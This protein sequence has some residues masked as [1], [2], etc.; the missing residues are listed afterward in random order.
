MDARRLSWYIIFT[1]N[2]TLA[3]YCFYY[4]YGY[5]PAA[6]VNPVSSIELKVFENHFYEIFGGHRFNGAIYFSD[7][8]DNREAGICYYG[9]STMLANIR[10]NHKLWMNY[11]QYAKEELIFHE[12][13]HCLYKLDHDEEKKTLPVLGKFRECP[14]SLMNSH[15][16][17]G[18]ECY[19]SN[20]DY[21]INEMRDK[22]RSTKRR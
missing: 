10:I 19:S 17:V 15:Q 6:Q 16:S 18:N 22:I 7:E 5:R 13:G 4:V 14:K 12:L 20:R 1:T 8:L 2:L 21:Y 11:T 9:G 3:S